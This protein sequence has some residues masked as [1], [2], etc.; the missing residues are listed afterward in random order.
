MKRI[1]NPMLYQGGRKKKKYFEGWYFKQ[2]TTDGK[3]TISVI[4]GISLDEKDPHC[5]I[6]V[7]ACMDPEVNP[8]SAFQTE[9]FRFPSED[10]VC[11]DEPFL[12]RIGENHFS[13]QGMTLHLA[14]RDIELLG[15]VIF[16]P[17]EG[18]ET[19]WIHPNIMGFFAY[20]PKMECYH[21]IISM[22]H[23]LAGGLSL[24]GRNIS[25]QDGI[26]YI[27]KDWGSSFP[28]SYL[29]L[30]SNHFNEANASIMCSVAT[31][32]FLGG[33]FQGFICNLQLDG[34]EYRFA[35]YNRSKLDLNEFTPEHANMKFHRKRLILHVDARM[36]EGALLQAPHEGAMNHKIKEGLFGTINIALMTKAGETIFSGTGRQCGI[37]LMVEVRK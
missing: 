17:F 14:G 36:E 21:G 29:W 4:P 16:G 20:L 31:I 25:F 12:I 34:R 10:F 13:E 15:N 27:E 23:T 3:A 24:N 18:I 5:F 28:S 7:I 32:P 9:Y 11:Q 8:K 2:A 1:R 35:S 37:E 22:K 33:S 30:Q 26:G 6:Q 19:S